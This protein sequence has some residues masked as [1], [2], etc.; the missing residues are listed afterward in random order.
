MHTCSWLAIALVFRGEEREGRLRI[1]YERAEVR[2]CSA[3]QQPGDIK[4]GDGVLGQQVHHGR[5]VA[6]DAARRCL[7]STLAH[8]V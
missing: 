7:R 6:V 1:W 5:I 3:E 4:A 2:C 8:T